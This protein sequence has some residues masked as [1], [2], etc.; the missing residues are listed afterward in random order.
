MKLFISNVVLS[1][2]NQ[3][4]V[5]KVKKILAEKGLTDYEVFDE[6]IEVYASMTPKE[7]QNLIDYINRAQ[8][9]KP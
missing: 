3:E 2:D 9:K 6:D 4:E 7:W 1:C 8:Q 5:R